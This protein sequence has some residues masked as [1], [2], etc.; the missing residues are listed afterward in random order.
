MESIASSTDDE[1][2]S[3]PRSEDRIQELEQRTRDLE[4][5]VE[6][7]RRRLEE[8]ESSPESLWT[9]QQ[10]ADYLSIS[11]RTVERII[12]RGRLN[13]LWIEGQRRFAPDTVRAYVR[14]HC[15]SKGDS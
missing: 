7:L 11:K 3:P 10:V 12:D 2:N 9:P 1:S 14:E 8:E 6:T 4:N 5:Q 13:P 15:T